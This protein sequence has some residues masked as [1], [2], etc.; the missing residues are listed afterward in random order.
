MRVGIDVGYAAVVALEMEPAWRDRSVEEVVRGARSAGP[1]GARRRRRNPHDFRLEPRRLNIADK[2]RP[3][4]PHPGFD[5]KLIRRGHARAGEL[6]AATPRSLPRRAGAAALKA[7]FQR[8]DR[9][10][11]PPIACPPRSSCVLSS[12]HVSLTPIFAG[13]RRSWADPGKST[14]NSSRRSATKGVQDLAEI[15]NGSARAPR[16]SSGSRRRL[17]GIQRP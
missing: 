12:R 1:G 13:Y 17:L 2:R 8:P 10:A 11:H 3:E 6:N 14:E 9:A 7:R 15:G 5:R 4:F 16:V